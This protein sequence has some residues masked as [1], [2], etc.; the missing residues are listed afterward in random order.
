MTPNDIYFHSLCILAT[1]VHHDP[2]ISCSDLRSHQ[3]VILQGTV[4]V[5]SIDVCI[6]SKYGANTTFTQRHHFDSL[7]GNDQNMDRTIMAIEHTN[8]N[9]L[10][11]GRNLKTLALAH[12]RYPPL[13]VM[14]LGNV[15]CHLPSL[16]TLFLSTFTLNNAEFDVLEQDNVPHVHL[17]KMQFIVLE[18]LPARSIACILARIRIPKSA[19]LLTTTWAPGSSH[20][21]SLDIQ[22]DGI[23]LRRVTRFICSEPMRISP[24]GSIYSSS[25]LLSTIF[26]T[27]DLRNVTELSIAEKFGRKVK[28]F[29]EW[30]KVLFGMPSLMHIN[31]NAYSA[32]TLIVNIIKALTPEVGKPHPCPGLQYCES[33]LRWFANSD[34]RAV[35][36]AVSIRLERVECH[37]DSNDSHCQFVTTF[38]PRARQNRFVNNKQTHRNGNQ[39]E[40]SNEDEKVWVLF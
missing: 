16:E 23:H 27:F 25:L 15:L 40:V 12:L 4:N 24:R 10:D 36:M 28:S 33:N 29:S 3:A 20:Q 9:L 8:A 39:L 2:F 26:S 1:P 19:P 21:F 30:R 13:D 37:Q 18:R 32:H 17:P 7:L 22:P 6:I 31:I 14:Q 38:G 35:H 34:E 11:V 5:F